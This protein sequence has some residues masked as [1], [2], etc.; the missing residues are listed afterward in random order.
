M[1]E[2]EVELVDEL[3]TRTPEYVLY[4]GASTTPTR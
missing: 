2:I 4:E 1:S 3:T